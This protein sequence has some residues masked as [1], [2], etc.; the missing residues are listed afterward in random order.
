M[1]QLVERANV[2]QC[3]N[4]IERD[5]VRAS[6]GDIAKVKDRHHDEEQEDQV[7]LKVLVH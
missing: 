7:G 1:R 4:E 2:T 5:S 6:T 3:E